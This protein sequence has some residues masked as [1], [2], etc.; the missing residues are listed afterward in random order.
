MTGRI[1]DMNDSNRVASKLVAADPRAALR[2][3]LKE[4][5]RVSVDSSDTNS[6]RLEIG[7]DR[8]GELFRP[9]SGNPFA[10]KT[11]NVH[12]QAR[13][14]SVEA[15]DSGA[16]QRQKPAELIVDDRYKNSK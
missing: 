8:S 11:I 15:E 9:N 14:A 6:A 12:Q 16:K 10:R 5:L 2:S 3:T 4:R 1:K 7:C 13:D